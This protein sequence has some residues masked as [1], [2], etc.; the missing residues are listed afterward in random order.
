MY[1]EEVA[2]QLDRLDLLIDINSDEMRR[3][4]RTNRG[5]IPYTYRKEVGF[6]QIA[7]VAEQSR[8]L[9]GVTISQTFAS[10]VS[11]WSRCYV[12]LWAMSMQG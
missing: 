5:I 6:D 1:V 11:V 4:Y 9:D 8:F 10:Q 3:H 2:P 7:L 12:T